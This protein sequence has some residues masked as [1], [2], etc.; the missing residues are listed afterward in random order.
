MDAWTK[1]FMASAD[2]DLTSG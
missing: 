2:I 1:V